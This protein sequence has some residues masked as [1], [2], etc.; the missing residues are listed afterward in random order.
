MLVVPSV[1][2]SG[3]FLDMENRFFLSNRGLV[4]A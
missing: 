3:R 1:G 4:M 2:V